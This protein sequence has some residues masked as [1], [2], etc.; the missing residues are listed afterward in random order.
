MAG[1]YPLT[2]TALLDGRTD[3]TQSSPLVASALGY[4]AAGDLVEVRDAEADIK[5]TITAAAFPDSFS[6]NFGFSTVQV[7]RSDTTGT[8]TVTL[9]SSDTTETT[10][11][12]TTATLAAGMS[13]T[14]L[15]LQGVDDNLLD[16]T[17]SAIVRATGTSAARTYSPVYDAVDVLDDEVW[18]L[19]VTIGDPLTGTPSWRVQGERP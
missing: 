10:P 12:T 4:A 17:Q 19:T 2:I 15:F 13:M 8:V 18:S 11:W 14:N 9:S 6:E 5:A 1:V 7:T 16:G 3:G